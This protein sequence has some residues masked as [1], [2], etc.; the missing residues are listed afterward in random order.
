MPTFGALAA[1]LLDGSLDKHF[2]G[3]VERVDGLRIRG[4]D[5][6]HGQREQ[7]AKHCLRSLRVFSAG[8]EADAATAN[9]IRAEP[10]NADETLQYAIY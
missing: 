3:C 2:L 4:L 7:V 10:V 1:T 9:G 6:D 5:D 8:A